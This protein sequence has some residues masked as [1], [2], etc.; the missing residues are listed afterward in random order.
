MKLH[1]LRLPGM[2]VLI[3]ILL[4]RVSF[5]QNYF[6][7]QAAGSS[8]TTGSNNVFVGVLTGWK[9][10]TGVDNAFY[11][12]AAG[13]ENT[14]GVENAFLGA[15]AG[16]RN[17][18]GSYNAFVGANAGFFNTVGN[19]NASLGFGAGLRNTNGSDNTMLGYQAGYQN[20]TSNNTFLGSEAGY[21]NTSGDANAFMGQ[22]AGKANTTGHSNSFVGK[23]AGL[24]NTT[25]SSNV[26]LGREAGWR[27]TTGRNNVVI[28]RNAG[29]GITTGSNNTF[30][31]H[32]A[33]M[34]QAQS[35]LS[36]A[37]AIGFRSSV[38]TSNSLVLGS[39][40]GVNGATADVNVGI[41]L[42][43]PTYR[44]QLGSGEA[45]K[46]G[47]S[48]WIVASDRQLKR[49]VVPFADG[50]EVV[51]QIKP[52]WFSYNGLAGM[53]KGKRFVG[54][55][56]QEMQKVAPYMIGQFTSQDT[57]GRQASYLDYDAGAL[58]YILV[59]AIR[60]LDDKYIR[61]LREKETALQSQQQQIDQL[62]KELT[63]IKSW[64]MKQNPSTHAE[65]IDARLWQNEPNPTDGSTV[66]RYFIPAEAF[67]AH[68]KL[69]NPNG[70]ELQSLLIGERGEGQ[71]TLR[72]DL[73]PPGTYF[74][75][76]VVDGQGV[77][78][79]RLLVIK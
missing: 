50:L 77:D 6:A 5:A 42:T 18:T 51:K 74:Y 32:H 40:N 57:T 12:K 46:P 62:T 27:N 75:Q 3:L 65:S 17:T 38:T 11:G 66:I 72:V 39:I 36:N 73:L 54:V 71:L 76:L 41:G 19:R 16:Y 20:M 21:A 49:D 67:S 68:L 43:N 22:Q 9:N 35:N 26:F 4:S 7:G 56:A 61:Q 79:K 64:L 53:P 10:T 70:Q 31:G 8:N 63:A 23:D 30:L 69:F 29:Y 48:A 1:S 2:A 59:N 15:Y 34:P 78:A 37:T 25:G 28:G 14:S 55:V 52:V 45:A 47:S 24:G 58:P 13:Q 44:L 33:S 60:E